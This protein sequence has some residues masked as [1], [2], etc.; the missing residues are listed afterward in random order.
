M[1]ID[2]I[3]VALAGYGE[4]ALPGQPDNP[5]ILQMAR[6][7]GFTDYQHDSTAWCSLFL[8]WVAWK[9]AY[10][11]SHSLAARSWLEVGSAA[12]TLEEADVVVFWRIDPNGTLG[13]VGIPIAARNGF[14]YVLG[15]NQSNQ[16]MIEGFDPAKVLGYRKLARMTL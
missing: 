2:L 6:E 13:H 15:G 1:N 12:E 16:V 4:R 14:I 5:D 9:A 10:E 8:C 7:V 3:R 11:R